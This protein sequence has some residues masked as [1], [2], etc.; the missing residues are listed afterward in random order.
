MSIKS[1]YFK[2]NREEFEKYS[3][4]LKQSPNCIHILNDKYFY[5]STLEINNL[6]I[7]LN[8]KIVQFDN[9][10][11]SFSS[12]AQKQI[13][14]SFLIEE[15][16]TTNKIENIN[17]TRHNIF[18]IINQV[19]NSKDKKIISISNAYKQLLEFG[20]IKISSNSDIRNLYDRILLGAI[21][22][23][24]LPDGIYYRKNAVYITDGL[25]LVHTGITQE[26]NINKL[27]NEFIS[28]YNSNID[29]L[30]KMILCH[31]MIEYIHPF[32]DGNG[33]LGR[34]LISNGILLESQSY[35]AF[36]ISKGLEHEK[37]KYYKAFKIASDKYEFGSLN[38]YVTTILEII[39]NEISNEIKELLY[40]KNELNN[41]EFSFKMTKSEQKIY[42]LLCEA[43]IFSNYGVSSEEI[44]KETGVSKRTLIYSLNKLRNNSMLIETKFSKFSYYKILLK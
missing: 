4:E 12:F 31:F 6:I 38:T 43:S 25:G 39:D 35:L 14:Q 44:L 26:E 29:M 32:Y 33:R 30:T 1:N 7:E 15:I 40:S 3:K 16:E 17:S 36:I 24:D 2:L 9:L 28:L 8:K 19:S 34:F 20:G 5:N 10:I 21:E 42:Y 41:L 18:K 23:Q 27:M 37:D 22:K 11:N 13:L